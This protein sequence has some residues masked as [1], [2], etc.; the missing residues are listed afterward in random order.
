MVGVAAPETE[1]LF[2]PFEVFRRE[3]TILGTFYKPVRDETR[4]PDSGGR[5]RPLASA[6]DARLSRWLSSR[7]PGTFT[8]EDRASRFAFGRMTNFANSSPPFFSH[9][10]YPL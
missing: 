1:V 10:S 2:R 7:K 3:L 6:C 9:E 8:S 5:P 4:G